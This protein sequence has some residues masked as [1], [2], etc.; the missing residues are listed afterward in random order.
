M[1]LHKRQQ[2]LYLFIFVLFVRVHVHSGSKAVTRDASAVIVIQQGVCEAI[3]TE[4]GRMDVPGK[5]YF[6]K[7]SLTYLSHSEFAASFR[8]CENRKCIQMKAAQQGRLQFASV[9]QPRKSTIF[10]CLK[11]MNEMKCLYGKVGRVGTLCFYCMRR[12]EMEVTAR[13]T[14][15]QLESRQ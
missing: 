12:K 6:V 13:A 1:K 10:C 4:N 14:L 7:I 11:Q 5:E 3:K 8:S 9:S 2:W 15:V